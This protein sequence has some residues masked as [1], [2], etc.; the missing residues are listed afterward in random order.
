M[1]GAGK[2]CPDGFRSDYMPGVHDKWTGEKR[3]VLDTRLGGML[4]RAHGEPDTK[5]AEAD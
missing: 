4:E 1:I 5:I 3:Q 2:I